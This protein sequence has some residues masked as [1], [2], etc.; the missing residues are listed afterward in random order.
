[1]FFLGSV[2]YSGW[3]EPTLFGPPTRHSKIEIDDANTYIDRDGSNNLIFKDANNSIKLLSELGGVDSSQSIVFKTGE[4]TVTAVALVNVTDLSFSLISGNTYY[5]EF[6][7]LFA[8][9]ITTT[10]LRLAVT[11]P[12]ATLASYRAEI[13]VA[14]DGVSG[15]FQGWGT[16]SGDGIVGTGVQAI[17]TAYLA[18]LTGI[19]LPSENGT[20][21]LQFGSEI[22]ASTVTV[23]RCSFGK[24]KKL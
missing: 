22:A 20:L 7:T 6:Y 16:A 23:Y 2:C 14:A 4:Q 19:I 15:D 5:Y 1:M 13:P 17:N 21:Q 8:T 18:N 11:Y 9:S 24:L 10:G 3:D 12:A